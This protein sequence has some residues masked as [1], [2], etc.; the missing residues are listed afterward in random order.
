ME[1][2]FCLFGG[3]CSSA[4]RQARRR[5]KQ[6]CFAP[7]FDASCCFVTVASIQFCP[8]VIVWRAVSCWTLRFLF[9]SHP[10]EL[11][12]RVDVIVVADIYIHLHL[13]SLAFCRSPYISIH[14]SSKLVH[15]PPRQ[16]SLPPLRIHLLLCYQIIALLKHIF[17]LLHTPFSTRPRTQTS[18]VLL[19]PSRFAPSHPHDLA[20]AAANRTSAAEDDRGSGSV[21]HICRCQTLVHSANLTFIQLAGDRRLHPQAL[22]QILSD[23]DTI[24]VYTTAMLHYA[25][26]LTSASDIG[27][28]DISS[29]TQSQISC[30][31]LA[32]TM[33][34]A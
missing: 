20:C 22:Y 2:R 7:H 32:A 15:S 29:P 9:C 13:T 12:A 24:G 8:G 6:L 26:P 27:N 30:T 3:P 4:T 10:Y 23:K 31:M 33:C 5:W 18:D 34:T 11:C 16:P 14:S 1:S 19:D 25:K 21:R 28:S 17:P